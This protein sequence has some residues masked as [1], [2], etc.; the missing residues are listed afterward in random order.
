VRWASTVGTVS[1]HS[2]TIPVVVDARSGRDADQTPD[3]E[4]V[5]HVNV[6]RAARS[7]KEAHESIQRGDTAAAAVALG[8]AIN[9]LAPMPA[10]AAETAQARFDLEELQGGRWSPASSKRLYAAMR[11]TQKGRRAR[12]DDSEPDTPA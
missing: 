3:A 2:V 11:S 10:Q 8:E 6:L 7:R 5:E 12:Y 4:V 9:L 1:L